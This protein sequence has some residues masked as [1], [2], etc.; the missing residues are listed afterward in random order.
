MPIKRENKAKYPKNWD[1][2]AERVKQKAFGRCE[3]CGTYTYSTPEEHLTEDE[4]N[5]IGD[6]IGTSCCSDKRK[7]AKYILTVHHKDRDPTNNS[8]DN[9]IALCAPCHLRKE[10]KARKK[11]RHITLYGS[12]M[13]LFEN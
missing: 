13:P 7:N 12:N 9:L 1:E 6:D 11:E 5:K 4:L 2:I 8:D 10:A 3:L